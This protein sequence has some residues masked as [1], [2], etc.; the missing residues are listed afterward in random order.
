MRKHRMSQY[1][2][3][4]RTTKRVGP[5]T[6]DTCTAYL[7]INVMM[8]RPLSK[9]VEPYSDQNPMKDYIPKPKFRYGLSVGQ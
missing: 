2:E 8:P 3:E 6:R 5:E 1:S 9:D 4:Q 7:D